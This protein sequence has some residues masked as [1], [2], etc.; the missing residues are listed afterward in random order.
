MSKEP[1]LCDT[2]KNVKP[3]PSRWAFFQR[4]RILY[5]LFFMVGLFAFIGLFWCYLWPLP[6]SNTQDITYLKNQTASLSR[7]IEQLE[8]APPF[9]PEQ[10][11]H[12]ETRLTTLY[13]QIES[14]QAQVKTEASPQP[15]ELSKIFEN[16]L[17]QVTQIQETLMSILLLWRLKTKI[18]ASDSYAP[19]LADFK[20]MTKNLPDL[21]VLEKYSHS[22]LG[23]LQEISIDSSYVVENS[24]ISWWERLKVIAKSFIKIEKVGTVKR[25]P[26]PDQQ[27]IKDLLVQLDQSLIQQLKTLVLSLSSQSGDALS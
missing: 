5:S 8:A 3:K 1:A 10:L 13:Q 21:S 24:P 15:N 11:R 7:R 16:S 4:Y 25:S 26:L 27:I 19:E 12:F 2:E 18:L 22:G 20:I 9:N 17:S 23:V 14:L 6:N